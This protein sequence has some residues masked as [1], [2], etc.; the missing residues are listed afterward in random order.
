[1][2]KEIS[3]IYYE[4]DKKV[5]FKCPFCGEKMV[6]MTEEIQRQKSG[7]NDVKYNEYREVT[8]RCPNCGFVANFHQIK[9]VK[10]TEKE[11]KEW[12]YS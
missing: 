2:G 6:K 7:F 5:Q 3:V 9:A 1:M 10:S 12:E 11:K 4:D 8:R